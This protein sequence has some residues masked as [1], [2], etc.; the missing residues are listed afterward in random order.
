MH[1]EAVSVA[2]MKAAFVVVALSLAASST[3]AGLVPNGGFEDAEG[4]RVRAWTASA[5]GSWAP[6][7]GHGGGAAIALEPAKGSG[8][9]ISDSFPVR[10]CSCYAYIFKTRGPAWGEFTAGTG[11]LNID[12]SAPS[13]N[14]TSH[15][16]V[17][18]T[19][20]AEN[21]NLHFGQWNSG[22]VFLF[23]DVEVRKVVPRYRNIGDIE[24]GH[25]ELVDGNRY[26]FATAFGSVARNHARP[27]ADCRS[28]FNTKRWTLIGGSTVTYRHA[29]SGRTWRSARVSTTC[30]YWAKG[31][32]VVEASS[33]GTE[34]VQVLAVTNSSV[35]EADVPAELFPA[36][37]LHVRFRGLNG[38]VVHIYDYQLKA[39]FE[40][41]PL[42]GIGGTS[43][44]DDEDG[45]V[46][47]DIAPSRYFDEGY[48]AQVPGSD[49][50]I[51]LWT[52]SSG[53]KINRT[54]NMP[55]GM[56]EGVVIRTAANESEA[57]QL[58]VR[59]TVPLEDVHVSCDGLACG[60]RSLPPPAIDILRVGYVDIKRPTD[61]AGCCALWPDPLPEQDGTLPVKAGENQPF[62]IRVKPPRGTARGV[63][64]GELR[65][66][67]DV[68]GGE[69]R[70]ISVPISVEVFGFDMPDKMT[71]ETAF[72]VE[73]SM[74]KRY[75]RVHDAAQRQKVFD[76][77]LDA[78]ASH[79]ISP[80]NPTPYAK[81]SVRW[82]GLG[83]SPLSAIPVFDWTAW[84]KEMSRVMSEYGFNTYELKLE[85]LGGGDYESV[86][87]QQYCGFRSGTPEY[88]ALMSK[89]L[90]GVE[91]HLREKG[92]LRQAYVYSFDEPRPSQFPIVTNGLS[93]LKRL[94][95]GIRR[96][97]TAKPSIPLQGLPNIWCPPS[98]L[99]ERHA[100]SVAMRN[101]KA[102]GDT[103]WWY[104]CAGPHAPYAGLLIDHPGTDLRVWLWQAWKHGVSGVLIWTT[105]WWTSPNAYRDRLQNPYEDAMSWLGSILR[106]K[107]EAWHP[108]ANGDGR[109]LYPPLSA[110]SENADGP[111]FDPPVPSIR[112]EMLRDGIEDYE[113]LSILKRLIAV[114]RDS[115]AP[116]EVQACEKLLEVPSTISASMTSFTKA[117]EPIEVHRLKVA[118]MIEKLAVQTG[119]APVA[120]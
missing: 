106:A 38:C 81:W 37:E 96:M 29:L 89:Y 120:D 92:W 27:L 117:P 51:G 88:E 30:G 41:I 101:A 32:A 79:H 15:T 47:V 4:G 17:I 23:D 60:N 8:S 48:G 70:N 100:N 114:R 87:G 61:Y 86:S 83:D 20:S 6:G 5:G 108:W 18:F 72:G 50:M 75:H 11:S 63:Y 14:W 56:A 65:V 12:F 77:Y 26:A 110:V 67:C 66:R 1:A 57:V 91:S 94:A 54:R 35:E 115:L 105:T 36:K 45:A 111:I 90:E 43:Y 64:R 93:I 33:N 95:P 74:V 104:V 2:G 107:N 52:A 69:A 39:S 109:L 84:D 22:G 97:V 40:G 46:M 58:V 73:M 21:E 102:A 7:S 44:I 71:C 118:R 99:V 53:W 112:L 16:N 78:L 76:L 98:Q 9:W 68:A 116:E 82:N 13:D 103:F 28:A 24:L 49:D 113:Y 59:P 25:G 42:R 10:P 119:K 62:W 34:W 31:S 3:L 80:Y 85:G 55:A 19:T